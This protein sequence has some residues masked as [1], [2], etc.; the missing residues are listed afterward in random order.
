M[1]TNEEKI[2]GIYVDIDALLDTRIATLHLVH[3]SLVKEAFDNGYF[4][5]KQD[6]FKSLDKK[7]FK[8]LY[9]T[10]DSDI[11]ENAIYTKILLLIQDMV[12]KSVEQALTTPHVTKV[13]LYINTHPYK[14]SEQE[15]ASIVEA[16][17]HYTKGLADIHIFNMTEK[18]LTP[19]FCLNN[20]SVLIKYDYAEWFDYHCKTEGVKKFP[21]TELTLI[22]PELFFNRL[23]TEQEIRENEKNKIDPFRAVEIF[24][25]PLITIKT[26]PIEM[27]CLDLKHT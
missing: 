23:P 20:L 1:D 4:T 8:E 6:A 17:A 10:R 5:R 7:S 12:D 26:M 13:I 9:E 11:L 15:E 18:E 24:F 22:V 14:L 25:S 19:E 16:M 2:Q 21:L 3:P 27:F